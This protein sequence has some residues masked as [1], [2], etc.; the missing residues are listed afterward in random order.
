MQPSSR[1][2]A[3]YRLFQAGRWLAAEHPGIAGP[4]DW[5]RETA[6]AYVAAVDRAKVGQWST[7]P[8]PHKARAGQP[9]SARSKDRTLTVVRTF[10]ADCQEWGWIHW[11]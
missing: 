6:A 7:T 5:T 3:V 8:G 10:F 1:V 9:V 11:R 4:G 2:S